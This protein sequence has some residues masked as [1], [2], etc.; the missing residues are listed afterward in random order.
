MSLSYHFKYNGFDAWNDI[1]GAYRSFQN[2][3]LNG[4]S[5]AGREKYS[6]TSFFNQWLM[7][8]KHWESY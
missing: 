5:L 8:I 1:L 6:A 4:N 3:P 2:F 7:E